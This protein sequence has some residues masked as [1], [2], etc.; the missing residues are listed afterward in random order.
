MGG[1]SEADHVRAS[2]GREFG[3]TDHLIFKYFYFTDIGTV[4]APFAS[5]P[6]TLT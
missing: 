2:Q 6:P 5:A 1:S 3:T 4:C